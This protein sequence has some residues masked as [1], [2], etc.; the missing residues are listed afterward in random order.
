MAIISV[1]KVKVDL[2]P[3][4]LGCFYLESHQYIKNIGFSKFIGSIHLKFHMKTHYHKL[5]KIYTKYF[6]HMTKM[7]TMLIHGKNI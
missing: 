7:A 3:Y 6:G 2:W 4:S 1:S 5:A